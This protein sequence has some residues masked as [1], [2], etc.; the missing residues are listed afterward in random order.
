MFL[1]SSSTPPRVVNNF[2]FVTGNNYE[3]VVVNNGQAQLGNQYFTNCAENDE[4]G[5][6]RPSHKTQFGEKLVALQ[7]ALEQAKISLNRLEQTRLDEQ[8]ERVLL[9]IAG[10]V[11]SD[12]HASLRKDSCHP[13]TGGWILECSKVSGWLRDDS[14]RTSTLWIHGI[15]GAGQYLV[16]NSRDEVN[17]SR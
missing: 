9:W 12:Y 17:V 6:T 8:F 1:D 11:M 2:R 5:G 4:G 3:Q 13:G 16:Y 10:P 14:P 15:P 7:H